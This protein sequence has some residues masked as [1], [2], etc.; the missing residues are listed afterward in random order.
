MSDLYHVL[1]SFEPKAVIKE[2]RHRDKE[3]LSLKLS[4]VSLRL[5]NTTAY[6]GLSWWN[7]WH[8]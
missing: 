2:R 3:L 4:P 7:L 8:L 1:L 6:C 5:M